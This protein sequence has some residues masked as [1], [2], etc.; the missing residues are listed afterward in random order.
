MELVNLILDLILVSVALWMIVVIRT[1]TLGSVFGKALSWISAGAIILG[2]AHL[3]ETLTFQV[4]HLKD[5]ALGELL[6]RLIVLAG[7][8]SLVIGFLSLRQLRR[9]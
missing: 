4:F 8:G 5:V 6:H 2:A 7:F 3:L 1:S 9:T